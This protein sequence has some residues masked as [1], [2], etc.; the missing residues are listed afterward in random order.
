M[1]NK[2]QLNFEDVECPGRAE[3]FQRPAVPGG[4]IVKSFFAQAVYNEVIDQFDEN[5]EASVSITFVPDPDHLWG[6]EGESERGEIKA[7]TEAFSM[8]PYCWFR[9]DNYGGHKG[10]II[11]RFRVKGERVEALD[12][13][14]GGYR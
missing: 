10:P 4:W 14:G 1:S 6:R 2:V 9:G 5:L 13:S 11:D 7:V 12:K 8:R 3:Y